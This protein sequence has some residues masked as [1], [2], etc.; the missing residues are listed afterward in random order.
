M[1]ADGTYFHDTASLIPLLTVMLLTQ[2]L[3]MVNRYGMILILERVSQGLQ[4]KLRVELYANL[5]S[6]DSAFFHEFRTGDLMTRLT[7]D[8]ESLAQCSKWACI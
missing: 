2:S 1:Q 3:R 5:S 6:Q 7:G 8:M 4:Q